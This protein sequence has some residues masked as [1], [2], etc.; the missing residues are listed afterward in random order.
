[1]EWQKLWA[2]NKRIIDP[3]CP[4]FAA[5][6]VEKASRL[7]ITNVS[8]QPEAVTVEQNK[9]NKALGTRPLWRS[10]NILIEFDDADQLLKVGEK[11]TLMNWG[12]VI[13]LTKDVNPDGSFSLTGEYLPED[14]DF[15]TTKKITWLAESKNLLIANL[16]E[17]DH[18]IKTPKVQEDQDFQEIVNVNSRF[19][20]KAYV[21]SG[22]RLLNSGKNNYIQIIFYKSREELITEQ[23]KLMQLE[24]ILS[25]I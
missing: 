8:E 1:M 23:I 11:V 24:M 2:I 5:V 12:N 13:I 7:I 21:D 16:V 22:L 3:I 20:S 17:Y 10:K 25:I 15:K 14:K 19:V 18:L 9:L 6:S 4:R